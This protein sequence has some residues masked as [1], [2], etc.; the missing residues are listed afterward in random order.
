MRLKMLPWP[1]T[2]L[3]NAST[4]IAIYWFPRVDIRNFPH[5]STCNLHIVLGMTGMGC[6]GAMVDFQAL[7]FLW[8]HATHSCTR[9][10]TNFSPPYHQYLIKLQKVYHTLCLGEKGHLR[11]IRNQVFDRPLCIWS[12]LNTSSRSLFFTTHFPFRCNDPFITTYLAAEAK[13]LLLVLVKLEGS[14]PCCKYFSISS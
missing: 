7:E 6:S 14:V 8:A 9:F 11:R 13:K 10:R 5:R 4:A 2:Y 1:S 3:V 12:A